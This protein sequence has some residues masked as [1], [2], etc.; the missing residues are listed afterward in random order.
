MLVGI[1]L[2][3]LVHACSVFD[4]QRVKTELVSQQPEI[5]LVGR[6]DVQPDNAARRLE[7]F[8]DCAGR[9]VAAERA[10]AADRYRSHYSSLMLALLRPARCDFGAVYGGTLAFF[11][12]S[13]PSA[14]RVV[15]A[16]R[17]VSQAISFV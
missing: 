11:P 9:D 2:W 8:G 17:H 5:V 14:C 7:R 4:C 12:R 13:G 16:D 6:L 10:T 15:H 3:T 1:N